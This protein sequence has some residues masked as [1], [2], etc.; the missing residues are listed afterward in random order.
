MLTES[1]RNKD[2]HQRGK[3]DEIN[4]I[5]P[6]NQEW[7]LSSSCENYEIMDGGLWICRLNDSI[8]KIAMLTGSI[9]IIVIP[10][11]NL[12]VRFCKTMY[13]INLNTF[14]QPRAWFFATPG[15]IY[16]CLQLRVEPGLRG[17]AKGVS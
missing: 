5:N 1:A 4:Q 12:P 15:R 8:T 13:P 9:H 11:D 6:N 14:H 3:S 2:G 10:Q 16:L 17:P 7:F